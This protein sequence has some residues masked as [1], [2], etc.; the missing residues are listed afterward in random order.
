MFQITDELLRE[1]RRFHDTLL[2]A[3]APLQAARRALDAAL[4]PT[5]ALVHALKA[6]AA[7]H[8]ALWM[9]IRQVF[10]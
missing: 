9:A 1:H 2:E 8:R 10:P 5:R 7:S 4:A 6:E 3:T